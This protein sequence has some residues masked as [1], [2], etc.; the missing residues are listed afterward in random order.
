MTAANGESLNVQAANTAE[1]GKSFAIHAKE[2]AS[3]PE[4]FKNKVAR[5]PVVGKSKDLK[6]KSVVTTRSIDLFVSRL[7]PLTAGAELVD[8]VQEVAT[9]TNVVVGDIKSV[10]LQ[11][12]FKALYSS[13]HVS[14]LVNANDLSQ[15][16][17]LYMAADSWP[18]GVF[19]KRYYKPKNAS[20]DQ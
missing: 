10:K 16:L 3:K 6:L 2:S 13:F 18:C 15:A 5:K 20:T 19:V 9:Q 4:A 14:M 7:H 11:S 1:K 17:E 8:C 12:K